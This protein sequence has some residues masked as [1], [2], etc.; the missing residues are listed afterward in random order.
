M[1]HNNPY[2]RDFELILKYVSKGAQ[3]FTFHSP[4]CT[5]TIALFKQRLHPRVVRA[6]MGYVSI[7]QTM[8]TYSH[9]LEEI[10]QGRCRRPR[11]GFWLGYS[12]WPL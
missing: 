3:G 9:L 6:L 12:C 7:V 5:F 8:E 11:R 2:Y 10:G 1:D 4:R